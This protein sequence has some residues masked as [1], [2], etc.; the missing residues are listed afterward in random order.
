MPSSLVQAPGLTGAAT[1]DQNATDQTTINDGGCL[2]NP[3]NA[4]RTICQTQ[5]TLQKYCGNIPDYSANYQGGDYVECVWAGRGNDSSVLQG[6]ASASSTSG[7]RGDWQMTG[8]TITGYNADA[9]TGK[10]LCYGDGNVANDLGG[11]K[12]LGSIAADFYK[13][14]ARYC[15]CRN[16]AP[17]NNAQ[18]EQCCLN[19]KPG[20]CPVG[21]QSNID[22]SGTTASHQKCDSFVKSHCQGKQGVHIDT[23]RQD[24]RCG[25]IVLSSSTVESVLKTS[26]SVGIVNRPD[27]F[28]GTCGSSA[29]K[30]AEYQQKDCPT[31]TICLANLRL[32]KVEQ[33][34]LNTTTLTSGCASTT[35]NT[36]PSATPINPQ[37]D[38]T[39][40]SPY[41]PPGEIPYKNGG[42]RGS[43]SSPSDGTSVLTTL[44]TGRT[45]YY[46]AAAAI[47]VLL[48]FV[49]VVVKGNNNTSE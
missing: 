9:S 41:L 21:Y 15:R 19:G 47:S 48:L 44:S 45:P 17:I 34:S 4:G 18:L 37:K 29:V 3:G 42:G 26:G 6:P 46:I 31:F 20:Y 5:T 7:Y 40:T 43:T 11:V 30:T 32:T 10:Y 2:A 14:D 49:V 24:P 16:D 12:A 28:S 8:G 35:S 36:A 13:A 23:T 39:A 38:P 1:C 27:C 25:C 33:A 22:G